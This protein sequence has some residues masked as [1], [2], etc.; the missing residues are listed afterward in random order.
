[1]RATFASG[2]VGVRI[3]IWIL[4]VLAQAASTYETLP[5]CNKFEQNWLKD[6]LTVEGQVVRDS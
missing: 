2:Y 4:A 3:H 6:Y 1:M 5:F